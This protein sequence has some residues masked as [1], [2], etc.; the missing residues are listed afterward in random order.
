MFKGKGSGFYNEMVVKDVN[1]HWLWNNYTVA[2]DVRPR[3][4]LSGIE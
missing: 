1:L 4:V 2:S 3:V